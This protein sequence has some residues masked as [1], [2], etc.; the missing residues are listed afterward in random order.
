MKLKKVIIQN[1]RNVDR[2]LECSDATI[3]EGKNMSGKT[4]TL[5]AI[6]WAF[7]G[8]DMEGSVDN[9]INFSFGYHAPISVELVFDT[10]SF[11]RECA[12][13]GDTPTT[14]IYID[15]VESKTT[16]AGEAMLHAKLG[17]SDIILGQPKGFNIVKFLL[18]PLYFETVAPKDLRMFFYKLSHLNF[19][20]LASAQTKAIQNVI[21]KMG[22]NDPY[23]LASKIGAEI[24]AEKGI[25]DAC[26]VAL[27]YFPSVKEEATKKQNDAYKKL[28]KLDADQALANKWSVEVS[29]V[30]NKYFENAMGIQVCLLEKGVG[31]DVYKDVCY[32]IL[33]NSKLPF[34]MGSQ[35]EKVYVGIKFIQEV[36]LTYN[37][38][39]LPILVDNMESLDEHTQYELDSLG[40]QYIGALVK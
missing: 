11:K 5:N 24:R 34:F 14:K 28:T 33:P 35:A 31:D 39:P 21:A 38:R 7:T 9:R 22:T 27:Q 18:N 29:K 15:K 37:I 30:V 23:L 40:V 4:N 13:E 12:F 19:D 17:L 32:P 26:K 25:L 1:F 36:C 8:A 20:S 10:F 6:H 16:K 2:E 3:I